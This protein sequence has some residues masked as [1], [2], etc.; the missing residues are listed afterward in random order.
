MLMSSRLGHFLFAPWLAIHF[1]QAY[2]DLLIAAGHQVLLNNLLS[3][4][5]KVEVHNLHQ[6]VQLVLTVG[7]AIK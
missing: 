1:F 3:D 2:L 7:S 6:T 4:L 5:V